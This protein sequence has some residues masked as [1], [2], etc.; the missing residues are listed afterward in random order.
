MWLLAWLLSPLLTLPFLPQVTSLLP[1][2]SLSYLT[3]WISLGVLGCGEHLEN[4][5]LARLISP[6]FDS[7]SSPPIDLYLPSPSSLLHV[8]LWT[9]QCV[10]HCG[11]FFHHEPR[12][13]IIC[14]IWMEKSLGYCKNKT[15]S[16]R[17]EAQIQNLRTPENFW[18]QGTLR[19]KSSAKSLHTYTETK[20]HPRANKFQS[21]TYHANSPATQEH[22]PGH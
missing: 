5:L 20:L 7:P 11:E 2:P 9:T 13:F 16:Q 19:D 10:P 14:A 4:W 3:L 6:P 15:E 22:S 8:T 18:F 12:C 21:K 17:Q 1:P